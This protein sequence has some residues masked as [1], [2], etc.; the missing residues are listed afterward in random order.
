MFTINY[1]DNGDGGGVANDISLTMTAVPEPS[2]W[3]TGGAALLALGYSQRR[4]FK[5]RISKT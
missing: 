3:V 1:L 5:N 4:R 2:T